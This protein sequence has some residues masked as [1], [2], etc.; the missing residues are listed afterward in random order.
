MRYLPMAL[1]PLIL[2]GCIADQA[3][4]QSNIAPQVGPIINIPTPKVLAESDL[5][6]EREDIKSTLRQEILA[7]SNNTQNQLSGLV[8]ASVSKLAEQV[9]GV[10]ANWHNQATLTAKIAEQLSNTLTASAELRAELKVQAQANLDAQL[11]IERMQTQLGVQAGVMNR[12]ETT[13]NDLRAGRDVNYVPKEMVEIAAGRERTFTYTIGA[14]LGLLA[15]AVGWLGRNAR[16]REKLRTEEERRERQ[17][18]QELLL[19]V[20]SMLPEGK[21]AEVARIRDRLSQT[22]PKDPA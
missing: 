7:S 4:R 13:T 18:A 20:L 6:K 3:N 19:H 17:Q 2:A 21:A 15:I 1:L 16:E 9:K 22:S 14:I 8:N 5:I 12:M 11:Q 10:E